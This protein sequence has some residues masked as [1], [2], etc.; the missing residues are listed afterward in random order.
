MVASIGNPSDIFA[1]NLNEYE[2][3]ILVAKINDLVQDVAVE[4]LPQVD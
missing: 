1:K 2:A 3:K 4:Q